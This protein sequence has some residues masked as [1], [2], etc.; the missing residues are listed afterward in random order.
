M[1]GQVF[2]KIIT[3]ILMAESGIWGNFYLSFQVPVV[4]VR[5]ASRCFNAFSALPCHCPDK[6]SFLATQLG[7]SCPPISAPSCLSCP[8]E[9]TRGA[10]HDPQWTP[11]SWLAAWS[12]PHTQPQLL[13]LTVFSTTPLFCHFTCLVSW[14]V[15]RCPPFFFSGIPFSSGPSHPC[16]FQ[17]K[18]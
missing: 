11:H 12:H 3:V 8:M 18:P 5:W 1:W 15:S 16:F 10:P 9:Q 6:H 14:A 2:T 17:S 13:S 4:V 7:S